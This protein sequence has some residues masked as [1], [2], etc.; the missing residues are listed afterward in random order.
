MG[1]KRI[2]CEDYTKY[3]LRFLNNAARAGRVIVYD[4]AAVAKESAD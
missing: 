3:A 1:E 2:N 4:D